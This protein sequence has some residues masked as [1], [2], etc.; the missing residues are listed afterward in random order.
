MKFPRLRIAWSVAWGIAAMLLCALW[1][2]SHTITENYLSIT[3]SNSRA[4]SVDSE[5]GS[6]AIRSMDSMVDGPLSLVIDHKTYFIPYLFL[7]LLAATLAAVPWIRWSNRFSLRTLLI[8]T[9]LIAVALGLIVWL[10]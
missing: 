4:F 10:R 6:V 5:E 3:L 2:R 7:V 8:A 9:T 1:V